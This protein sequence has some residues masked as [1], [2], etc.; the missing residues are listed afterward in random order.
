MLL[1]STKSHFYVMIFC[2]SA[3]SCSGQLLDQQPDESKEEK[4]YNLNTKIQHNLQDCSHASD[5]AQ[6]NKP[7][8]IILYYKY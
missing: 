8:N 1:R 2:S 4:V 7:K 3:D 5:D 6:K